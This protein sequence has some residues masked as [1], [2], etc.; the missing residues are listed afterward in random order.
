MFMYD[1]EIITYGECLKDGLGGGALRNIA[2][3][4]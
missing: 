4:C 2:I 1:L 3:I